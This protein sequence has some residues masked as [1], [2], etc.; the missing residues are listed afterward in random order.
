[1]EVVKGVGTDVCDVERIERTLA[2]RGDRFLDRTYTDGERNYCS[3]KPRPA[4][5]YAGRFAVKEAVM[6]CLG[7]GLGQEGVAFRDI[8]VL[9]EET[10][11][12]SVAVHGEVRAVA[13]RLGV[14]RFEISMSHTD[15]IAVAFAVAIGQTN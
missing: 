14:S 10:G 1:M 7:H 4:V 13:D 8:E 12:V 15:A 11:A 3:E 6:K 9:R 5:H 2:N